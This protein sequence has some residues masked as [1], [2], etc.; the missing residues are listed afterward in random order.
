M[1]E[2]PIRAKDCQRLNDVGF[3]FFSRD[4]AL[5]PLWMN[6]WVQ[7]FLNRRTIS[8]PG[9]LFSCF[10]IHFSFLWWPRWGLLPL[11]VPLLPPK[12][13]FPNGN[14]NHCTHYHNILFPLGFPMKAGMSIPGKIDNGKCIQHFTGKV[15]LLYVLS[16]IAD[17]H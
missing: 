2:R 9:Q 15:L 13:R 12:L 1:Y 11:S 10:L 3:P 16:R 14:L 5:I 4:Y 8:T 7:I 6:A 17:S